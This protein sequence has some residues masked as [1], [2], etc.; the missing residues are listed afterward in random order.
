[1]AAE[2]DALGR[3]LAIARAYIASCG[4][5]PVWPTAS[6]QELRAALGGELPLHPVDPVDVVDALARAAEPGL[7]TNWSTTD[8]DVDRSAHAIVRAVRATLTSP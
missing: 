4:E 6:L 7:V 8:A 3:A 5:R 1:V 2:D